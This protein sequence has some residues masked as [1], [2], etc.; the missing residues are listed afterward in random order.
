MQL[1]MKNKKLESFLRLFISLIIIIVY[2]NHFNK[3]LI[4]SLMA[5]QEIVRI[6]FYSIEIYLVKLSKLGTA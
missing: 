6:L 4:F 2:R 3:L 1:K 5:L